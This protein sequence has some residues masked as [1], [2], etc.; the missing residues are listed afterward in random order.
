VSAKGIISQHAD[1]AGDEAAAKETKGDTMRA[2]VGG[3]DKV[4]RIVV[5]LII[6]AVGIIYKSWWGVVGVPVLFT[7]L[8]NFCFAYLPFGLSTRKGAPQSPPAP[9]RS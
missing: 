1:V 8:F 4:I 2:N 6:I 5:G 9:G 7:G 3:V